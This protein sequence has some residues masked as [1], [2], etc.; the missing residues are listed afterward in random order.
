MITAGI[1]F[2]RTKVP[3]PACEVPLT[4][5]GKGR[6][7]KGMRDWD[8]GPN[9]PLALM[10]ST[11]FRLAETNYLDDQTWELEI[12]SGEAAALALVTTF[13]LRA[14]SMRLFPRFVLG[15]RVCCSPFDFAMPPRLRAFYPNFL[16]LT[17]CPVSH[18]EVSAEYW[19]PAA[20]V[21]AGRWT[22]INRAASPLTLTLEQCA[23][24]VPLEGRGMGPARLQ[25]VNVLAG[26]SGGLEI[27]LFLTGG[28]YPGTG[29]YPALAL[30]LLLEPQAPRTLTWSLAALAEQK[31]AFEL[32]RRTAARP[33]EAER[34]RIELL[35][36]SQ[37]IEIQSGNPDWDAALALSQKEAFRLL[38]SA[39][40]H[41]PHPSPVLTRGPDQG[42]SRRADGR[43]YPSTWQGQTPL[44]TYYLA[45]LLPGAPQVA[46]D[47]LA[48]FL[49]TRQEDGFVDCRPGLAGQR[50]RRLAAPLLASL[51]WLVSR[52]GEEKDFLASVFPN[53]LAFYHLWFSPRHDRD[54]DGFPEWEHPLQAGF[55]GH[56]VG[57]GWGEAQ[58]GIE[59][60]AL[61]D[62]ALGAMLYREG[63]LLARMAELLQPSAGQEAIERLVA[64]L[65]SAIEECWHPA[66]ASYRRRD[67]RSHASPRGTR[68]ARHRG[69]GIWKIERKFALPV[70]LVLELQFEGPG[71]RQP[72]L[73]LRGQE[74][75]RQRQ[76]RLKR[77]AFQS[78]AGGAFAVTDGLFTALASIEVRG[79]TGRDRWSVGVMDCARA[80]CT[81][82]LPLW[83]A[84]PGARQAQRLLHRTV[85]A[86]LR[87][88]QAFGIPL[89]P[90]TSPG[91]ATRRPDTFEAAWG[92]GCYLPWIQLIGEGLLA[93]GWRE[94]A[95]RLL[96]RVMA[97]IIQNLQQRR[98]FYQ[99]YHAGSG[100]GMGERGH[101][102]G[103]APLGL[104]LET[105]GVRFVSPLRVMLQGKNPFP[106]PVV[107][108][109][110]GTR[111][112]RYRDETVVDFV[113]GRRVTLQDPTDALIAAE[114]RE[115]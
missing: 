111:V 53:L 96:E 24:L 39:T 44:E 11:D 21:V 25:Q 47:L 84:L 58:S 61:E 72:E 94:E 62:P 14:R 48:N 71:A 102:A 40:E 92:Q 104:F 64:R 2:S 54:E 97:A 79:L 87:F 1:A 63:R 16:H 42:F 3:H 68:L 66:A 81:L 70:R 46:A 26:A 99:M 8:L 43:D 78:G 22:L 80:D 89:L 35:N 113:N 65:G 112:I 86:P 18:L 38:L 17:F 91:G 107:V 28:P 5:P 60:S 6:I 114:Q 82:L 105:L 33:W 7:L 88:G 98:A 69:N 27:V 75:R 50:G 13:G 85:N 77:A 10:I 30:D 83:A 90:A 57:S 56:L 37:T 29:T 103:L 36:A 45:S 67:F 51:A 106:W 31:A 100:A 52:Q 32:A 110:R 108:Q 15:E 76:E 74:G 55:D 73:I 41:L 95:A 19:K 115:E 23:V 49:F 34:A 9:D 101:L 93:Y 59:F 109:Y 20:S 12:G 4:C